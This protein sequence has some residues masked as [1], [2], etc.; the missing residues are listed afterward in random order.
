MYFNL[1]TS[2]WKLTDADDDSATKLLGVVLNT[3]AING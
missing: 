3:A 2:K 1:T